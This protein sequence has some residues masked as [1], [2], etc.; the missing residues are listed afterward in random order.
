[1]P[2]GAGVL[3]QAAREISGITYPVDNAIFGNL[4]Q[5]AYSLSPAR[6][7]LNVLGCNLANGALNGTE[8][9]TAIMVPVCLGDVLSKVKIIIGTTKGKKV[10]AGYAALYA[11]KKGGVLLAQSKSA[12]LAETVVAENELTF[13]LESN[14]EV[15]KAMAPNGYIYVVVNLE[16]ETMPSVHGVSIATAIQKALGTVT[17]APE[18]LAA[19]VGSGLKTAAEA[20]LGTTTAVAVIPACVVY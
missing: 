10:E 2:A 8:V 17:G 16:A 7:N 20:T 15:T 14:V 19:S 12:K 5:A 6:S 9:G 11:G 1:M 18:F 4:R 13:T 3:D